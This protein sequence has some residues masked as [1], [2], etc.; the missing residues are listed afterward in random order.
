MT[1]Q[2][3]HACTGQAWVVLSSTYQSVTTKPHDN[4][5]IITGLKSVIVGE[6]KPP[7]VTTTHQLAL[8]VLER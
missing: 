7:V 8:E 2:P 6:S 5:L 3:S 1:S 4:G